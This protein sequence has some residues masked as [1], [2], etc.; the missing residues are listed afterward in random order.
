MNVGAL[1]AVTGTLLAA[2]LANDT[3]SSAVVNGTVERSNTNKERD[4]ADAD[5]AK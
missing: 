3:G 5:A 4:K 1:L 2:C